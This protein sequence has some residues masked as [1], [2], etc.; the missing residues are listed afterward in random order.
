MSYLR[1]QVSKGCAGERAGLWEGDV[2]VEVNGE[3]VEEEHFEK[4]LR[5]IQKGDTPLR[6]LVVERAGYEHL[7][8]SGVPISSGMISDSIEV[9]KQCT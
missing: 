9:R 6:L 2:V 1:L 3:N 7:R 4:V 5:L 8:K